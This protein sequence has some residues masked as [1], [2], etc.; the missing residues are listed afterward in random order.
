[1]RLQFILV[2]Q[3]IFSSSQLNGADSDPLP[4][5]AARSMPAAEITRLTQKLKDSNLG[6]VVTAARELGETHQPGTAAGLVALYTEGDGERRMA[7][8]KAL[9][10]LPV[11]GIG[12]RSETFLAMALGD[13][14][15]AIR[16]Q[17]ARE[18]AQSDGVEFVAKRFIEAAR[19]PKRLTVERNRAIHHAAIIDA[20]HSE[21]F[22]REYL[23][24]DENA[25]AIAAAEELGELRSLENFDALL[26]A[27]K[28]KRPELQA[29]AMAALERQTGQQFKFDLIQWAEHRKK[30]RPDFGLDESKPAQK[31][32]YT[33]D[34]QPVD[35]VIAF[36]TTGSFTRTWPDVD[37]ALEG[38]LR[39]MSRSEQSLR[40]GL[41]RYRALDVRVT[42]RYT[43]QPTPFT[44]NIDAIQKEMDTT[45]FGGG[46]GALHTALRYALNGMIWRERSRKVILIIGDDSPVS[47]SE[48]PLKVAYQLTH[49]AAVLDGI[50]INTLY[51]KT[52]A[53]E[54]NRST[55]REIAASGFGRFYEYNKSVKHLVEMSADI[56]NPKNFELPEETA[57]KFLTPRGK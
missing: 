39:E 16:R 21:I 12:K 28:T 46:S 26:G 8:V 23:L 40:L 32:E 41:V 47:T 52:I 50:Q 34:K 31:N 5:I 25:L 29:A 6:N 54:E 56:V 38:V 36:D 1:M 30:L 43:L 48:D 22:L 18:W 55:Y 42:L 7:A 51:A 53:G 15:P 9:G 19:D 13:I 20:E 44:W 11:W 10:N 35:L 57:R 4:I 49:D 3:F 14:S 2:L 33:K 17:A 45:F 27:L 37:R 24:N